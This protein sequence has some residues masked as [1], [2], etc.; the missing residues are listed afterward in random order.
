MHFVIVYIYRNKIFDA[1][2]THFG[3]HSWCIIYGAVGS[4]VLNK[5]K[6]QDAADNV[7]EVPLPVQDGRLDGGYSY[8]DDKTSSTGRA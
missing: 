1:N 2:Y 3:V 4:T 5:D 8:E 7:P 6:N